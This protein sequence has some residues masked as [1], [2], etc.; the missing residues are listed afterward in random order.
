MSTVHDQYGGMVEE[1][2]YGTGLA[3]TRFFEIESESVTGKYNRIE[4]AGLRAGSRVERTDRWVPSPKGADGDFKGE[5]LDAGF[6]LLFKHM[7]GAVNVGTPTGGFTPMTFTSGD[8]QG[9]SMTWQFG[10]V[11][12][13]GALIPATYEGGKVKTWELTNDV[14]GLMKI[15]LALDF[16][17]ETF[18][19]GSSQY[20]LST[21]TYPT[22]AQL[23]S[24]VS[25]SATIAGTAMPV[26]GVAI[27]GDNK[28][29]VGR[30][31]NGA[32][33]KEP[34][35]EDHRMYQ[36]DLKVEFD[37]VTQYNRVASATNAGATASVVLTW[38]SPQGGGLTI[39]MPNL[40]FDTMPVNINGAKVINSTI[41]G[42][43]L[44]DGTAQPLTLLYTTKD[45][46][47]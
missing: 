13:T 25:G 43:A 18:G 19:A 1:L 4:A 36:A 32:V 16:M 17:K 22:T 45:A 26:K 28:L 35:E 9:L 27:K 34:L 40:R 44:D 39:T 8:L 11:T 21:P 38:A 10:R 24:Y 30:W 29:D 20:A 14:D 2:V 12:N 47:P 41:G 42:K 6:G 31:F 15:S 46:A 23:F 5:V 7:L 33:K 37:G 3:V